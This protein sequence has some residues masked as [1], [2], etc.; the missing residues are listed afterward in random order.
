MKR[1]H[2]Q[3]FTIVE[4]MVSLVAVTVGLSAIGIVLLSAAEQREESEIRLLVLDRAQSIM[5][6]IKGASADKIFDDY[7]GRSFGVNNVTG[8]SS[9]GEV[10]TVTV[11]NSDPALIK[12]ILTAQWK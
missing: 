10:I 11:D 12:V 8:G 3:G 5:E 6:E 1:S 2:V 9:P 4:M 7:D